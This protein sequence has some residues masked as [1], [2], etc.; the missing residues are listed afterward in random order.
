MFFFYILPLPPS[1]TSFNY[2]VVYYICTII[3]AVGNYSHRYTRHHYVRVCEYIFLYINY[4]H[5]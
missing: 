4:S 3:F 2:I 1:L 5:H